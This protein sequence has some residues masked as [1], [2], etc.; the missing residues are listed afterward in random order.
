LAAFWITPDFVYTTKL[1]NQVMLRHSQQQLAAPWNATTWIVLAGAA[2]LLGASLWRRLDAATAFAMALIA[3]AGAVL[4]PYTAAG[5]YLVPLPH[6]YTQEFN[7]GLVLAIGCIARAALRRNRMMGAAVLILGALPAAPFLL[8]AWTAQP[9]SI[10]PR[11]TAAFQISDWLAHHAGSARVLVSGELEGSLNIWSDVPQVSGSAQGVW[12]YLVP[13]AH[14]EVTLGCAAGGGT[15][16]AELWLRALS[17]QYLVVHGDASAE[18]FHWFV[19]PERFA[20]FPAVW[21]N[22]HGDTI[23]RVPPPDAEQAVVVDLHQL[24]QLG[25]LRSTDDAAYLESYVTWAR[26]KRAAAIQWLAPGRAEIRTALAAGEGVLVKVNYNPGW[27]TSAGAV[28][29]DPIGF[30]LITGAHNAPSVTLRFGAPW[31]YWVGRA[32]TLVTIVLLLARIPAWMTGIAALLPALLAYGILLLRTP[33]LVTV[34]EDTFRRMQPPLIN[35]QGI[36]DAVTSAQ[37]P[38]A[39]G[40]LVSIFGTGFGSERDAVKAWIGGREAE[41]LYRSPTLLHVRLPADAPPRAEAS[42]EVNGCRGNAFLV[43]VR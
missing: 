36:V 23:Y 19:Q 1:L 14:R 16:L 11:A 30:L 29:P 41:I 33:P 27:R 5:N 10:D 34:A 25:Q 15:R 26:G 12:N 18:H 2:A 35:A 3:I 6:R 13:A 22:G 38:L 42:I 17:V 24:E 20:A 37:P 43:A 4:I 8:H 31:G 28:R 32:V 39:R 21:S 7:V 40:S 9:H